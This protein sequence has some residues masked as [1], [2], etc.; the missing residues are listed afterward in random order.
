M[1]EYKLKDLKPFNDRQYKINYKQEL[2]EA[3][4]SAVEQAKGPVLV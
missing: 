1:K 3:Q 2:N 4:F